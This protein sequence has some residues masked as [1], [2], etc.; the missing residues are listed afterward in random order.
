MLQT[1][2]DVRTAPRTPA[3]HCAGSPSTAVEQLY[4]WLRTAADLC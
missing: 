1:H 3:A 4:A 2:T